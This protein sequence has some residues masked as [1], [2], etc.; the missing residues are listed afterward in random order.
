MNRNSLYFSAPGQ[1]ELRE[2]PLPAPASGQL[3]V[4]TVRSAIS[5]GTELLIYRDQ[6]PPDLTVDA[7]LPALAGSFRFP[8]KYGYAAVGRVEQVGPDLPAEWHNRLVF[9]FNPHES[10][11]LARPADLLPL[12]DDLAPDLAVFV[13]N[14]E[15]ALT[16]LLDG[17]PLVG[18]QVAVFGQ[19]VVGLLVTAL[20]ARLPLA[21][22]VSLDRWP[23]RRAA[24]TALGALA[25]L[26][27]T[28][29]DAASRLAT[30]LQANRPYPGADL[31]YEL[32]GDPAALDQALAAAGFNARVVIGSWYG[33][34]RA[35]LDLGGRFHRARQHLIASQVSTIPPELTGR[36]TKQRRLQTVL[37]LL[38]SLDPTRLI[39]HRFPLQEAPAAYT[40]LDQ[41]PDEAIQVVLEYE[42]AG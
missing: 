18:E 33:R 30:L 5:A 20:L 12:P 11:F 41:R 39:T 19:G 29:P 10:H 42:G 37:Q 13:P 35:S 22:L 21:S 34:K 15:T 3:L 38:P 27:P 32:S 31:V 1:V 16:L 36:W 23:G 24:A 8:L 28:A 7:T 25:S 9:A 40:L 14:V 2:E 26:D 6:A 4:R 17:Q